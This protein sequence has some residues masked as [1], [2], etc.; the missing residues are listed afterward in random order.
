MTD[1]ALNVFV[2]GSVAGLLS[3]AVVHPLDTLRAR[4]QT[5]KTRQKIAYRGL[6]NGFYVVAMGTIPGHALYF[7]GYE[8]SKKYLS[9]MFISQST[10]SD[11]VRQKSVQMN[12]NSSRS[13]N[14]AINL[15]SGLMAEF[16]GALAWTP[17]DVIKQRLQVLNQ[18]SNTTMVESVQFIAQTYRERGVREF[19]RGFGTALLV[20]GPFVSLYFG[21]YEEWKYYWRQRYMTVNQM[22]SYTDLESIKLP[23]HLYWTGAALSAAVAATVTCPIDVVKTRIQVYSA[24]NTQAESGL[25]LKQVL[26]DL[27]KEEGVRGLFR[28]LVPRVLWMS[29]GTALTMICYEELK[30]LTSKT[31]PQQC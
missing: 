3:D 28:G 5:V 14:I 9:D 21:L 16:C 2:I 18:Q 4:L 1:N 29:G 12:T 19:Y 15:T 25:K 7:A 30:N 11:D 20:Y 31:R 8:Y 27:I 10:T 17:M 23:T 13:L 6:Y 26:S 22:T 24:S